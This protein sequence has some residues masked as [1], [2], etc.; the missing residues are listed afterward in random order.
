MD[1]SDWPLTPEPAIL[2]LAKK[3]EESKLMSP[4]YFVAA[5]FPRR[6]G[7]PQVLLHVTLVLVSG[8]ALSQSSLPLYAPSCPGALSHR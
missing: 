1:G 8:T 7:T 4:S 3:L 5:G 6:L 2:A